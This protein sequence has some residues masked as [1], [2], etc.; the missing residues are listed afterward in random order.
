MN[1]QFG[2]DLSERLDKGKRPLIFIGQDECAI[3]SN[4]F[5]SKAWKGPHGESTL[6]PKGDGDSMMISAFQSR[7]FG[8]GLGRS[9]TDAELAIVNS[10]RRKDKHYFSGAAAMEG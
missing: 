5:C 9:L 7:V 4:M 2:G 1:Q 10:N 6:L 3:S 8:L